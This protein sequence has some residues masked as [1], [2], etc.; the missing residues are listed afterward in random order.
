M[1]AMKLWKM[2]KAGRLIDPTGTRRRIQALNRLGWTWQE[3]AT[4]CGKSSKEWVGEVLKSERVHST[5]VDSVARLYAERSMTIPDGKQRARVR[6]TA[7]ARGYHPP[8]AWDDID[9]PAEIPSTAWKP[10]KNRPAA[11]LFAELDH[12]LS[13]GVSEFHAAKQLGVTLD[14]IEKA[15]E[16]AGKVA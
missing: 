15:R 10:V 5:T 14:A 3:I 12:L 9:D 7:A 4:G 6:N 13:L 8:L 11:E 2:G 1:R 16:R